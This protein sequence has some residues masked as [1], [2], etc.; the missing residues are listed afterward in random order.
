MIRKEYGF[1]GPSIKVDEKGRITTTLAVRDHV[2]TEP[3]NKGIFN[4]ETGISSKAT[5]PRA[6]NDI[7]LPYSEEA[8]IEEIRRRAVDFGNPIER[9]QFEI[10]DEPTTEQR[11]EFALTTGRSLQPEP[12]RVTSVIFFEDGAYLARLGMNA[13]SRRNMLQALELPRRRR[14][15]DYDFL[16]W[17]IDRYES[18]ERRDGRIALAVVVDPFYIVKYDGSLIK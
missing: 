18:S 15:T 13:F 6:F 1:K 10:K 3:L 5:P 14:E 17:C 7:T 11:L 16:L 4:T 12:Y 9:P 2:S 8:H